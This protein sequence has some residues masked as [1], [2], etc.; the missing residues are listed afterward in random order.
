LVGSQHKGSTTQ[1]LVVV[2]CLDEVPYCRQPFLLAALEAHQGGGE[3]RVPT[4][5]KVLAP[6]SQSWDGG[7]KDRDRSKGGDAHRHPTERSCGKGENTGE[8]GGDKGKGWVEEGLAAQE[9]AGRW[10]DP[11]GLGLL[12]REKM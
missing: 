10:Q 8:A 1:N 5:R 3:D 12:P 2:V 6:G 4:K 7:I 11:K 9:E